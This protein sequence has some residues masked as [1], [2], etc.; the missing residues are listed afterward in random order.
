MPVTILFIAAGP[1]SQARLGLD[2]EIRQIQDELRG[3]EYQKE[4]D[5]R[6]AW[7]ARPADL[8]RALNEFRPDVLHFS[9]HGTPSGRLVYVGSQGQ[10]KPVSGEALAAALRS[11]GENVRLVVLNACYSSRL[12]SAVIQVVPCV[13]GMNTEVGDEAAI[14]FAA[15]FYR[16]VGFGASVRRA[17]DQ[18]IAALLLEGI[19]EDGTPELMHR[20]D[21]DPGLIAIAGD[22]RRWQAASAG[23][24]LIDMALVD[25][26]RYQMTDEAGLVRISLRGKAP[27]L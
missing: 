6:A 15:A 21:V 19:P 14:T 3:S 18:A 11:A 4:I 25:N 20:P 17:F 7:A 12:A 8:L 24:E 26:S 9:G 27:P 23:I 16:A 1:R 22:G 5:V 2:E 10:P 13:V